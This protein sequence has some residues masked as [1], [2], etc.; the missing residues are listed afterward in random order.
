MLL[1]VKVEDESV[2]ISRAQ[3]GDREAFGELVSR[4]HTRVI[5]VIYRMCWDNHLAEDA[6]QIA[7][8]Q[9]WQHLSDF[10]LHST[11]RNWL[12]RIAVNAAMDIL[13]HEKPSTDI[14]ELQIEEP[15]A[16]LEEQLE[17]KE[18]ARQVRLAVLALPEASRTVL[19]LRE[20]EGLSYN[21]IAETL[22]I[23]T[24]TVMSRLNYARR[25]LMELLC[26]YLEET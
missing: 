18:R 11:F 3:D 25:R 9:A 23:S 21:E 19:I 14:S 12:Y 24:G 4:Y 6:A 10:R 22:D 5:N 20:Y 2:L 7:F 13:R 16:K 1:A 15:A 26:H 8:I 17:Q